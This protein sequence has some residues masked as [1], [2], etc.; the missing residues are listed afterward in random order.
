MPATNSLRDCAQLVTATQEAGGQIPKTLANILAGAHLLN[1]RPAPADP[2]TRSSKR[3]STGSLT[4]AKLDKLLETTA[5]QQIVNV[6]AGDLRQRSERL[7]VGGSST[8]HSK[9]VPA[10]SC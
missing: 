10:M 3:R 8:R 7:F 1:T 6:Y 5:H 4:E 9:L 2:P